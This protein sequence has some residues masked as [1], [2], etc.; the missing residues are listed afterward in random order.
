MIYNH[1]WH[2]ARWYNVC[3][4]LWCWTPHYHQG[5][6]MQFQSQLP[7]QSRY[8]KIILVWQLC[9]ISQWKHGSILTNSKPFWYGRSIAK[10]PDFESIIITQTDDVHFNCKFE[11]SSQQKSD[12]I[13]AWR[14]LLP[15]NNMHS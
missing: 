6:K 9:S 15:H 5:F 13:L 11:L 12:A 10:W 7:F 14:H 1:I 3:F 2:W 8:G 4:A